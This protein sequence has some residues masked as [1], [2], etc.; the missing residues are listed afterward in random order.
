MTQFGRGRPHRSRRRNGGWR[1]RAW[2]DAV[3]SPDSASWRHSRLFS[4]N[5]RAAKCGRGV[6][7]GGAGG[8]VSGVQFDTVIV[9]AGSAGCVLA[10]R[11]S[12]DPR[13]RVCLIEAGPRDRSPLIHIPGGHS[14]HAADAPG[15]LG[16]P[17]RAAG[18]ARR[19]ARLP[20]ARARARRLELHQ[21]D[22]L[23]ARAPRRTTT[24]GPRSA[25]R[26]GPTTTCCRC[27]DAPRTSS[28]GRMPVPRQRRRTDGLGSREPGRRRPAPSSNPRCA[29]AWRANPDFNGATP[30]RGGALPGHAAPRPPLQRGRRLPA[31][32]ARAPEP[33]GADRP[34]CDAHRLRRA[35]ARRASRSRARAAR[36]A[37][38]RRA[39]LILS[40]GV[41]GS[42]QLLLLSGVGPREELERHG[43]A[44]RHELPG[45]GANL[46][47][48]VDLALVYRSDDR[49]LMGITARHG[50]PRDRRLFP[51]ARPRHGN[52]DH[53]LRRGRRVPPHARGPR[54]AGHPAP[55][56]QSGWWTTM[57]G[58]CTTAT[59]FPATSRSCA[60]RAA[61][62]VGLRSAD[63]RDAAA[64]R[65]EFPRGGGRRRD[66]GGRRQARARDH[67]RRAAR[68]ASRRGA[69]CR[70][71]RATRRS[72]RSIRRRADTIYH[73]VG[74]CRM[75]ADA[76]AVVD[77][78][79]RVRGLEGLS[80]VDASVMP[81]LVGGNTNAPTVMIAE[82]AATRTSP[83][84]RP[85]AS[86]CT[87]ENR[88]Q[89]VVARRQTR[90]AK[91][92]G[93]PE[94]RF[95]A[96][97]DSVAYAAAVS[98]HS[99]RARRRTR[100]G[101]RRGAGRAARASRRKPRA[102]SPGSS[103]ARTAS[104]SPA[105]R[106][107][108]VHVPS[109][110]T[111][112]GHDHASGQFSATGLR[113]GGPY[114]VTAQAEGMQDAIGRGPVHAARAAHLGD[115]RRAADRDSSRASR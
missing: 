53:Q 111:Q 57:R 76:M 97:T 19:P 24:T 65:P 44:V 106:V 103:S 88:G 10:N 93:D 26:A 78:T 41:F 90:D 21:R 115:A 110:T 7:F 112:H 42:P 109:G 63:P 12:A 84:T 60:R 23:H 52:P 4:L 37:S 39:K 100:D 5:R 83:E 50:A 15:E 17:D 95:P 55:L 61:G 74:T 79:L 102:S 69:V 94:R 59:A 56:R 18:R 40:A 91:Q 107:T 1:R 89:A 66:A 85:A 47:D 113:V 108:I 31:S 11:L 62:S 25:I 28:A 14:R 46:V 96:R 67:G 27:S 8:K 80:V 86:A 87:D 75:G 22:D 54:P 92:S 68:A 114:R 9:G 34:P 2:R 105:P 82:K 70:R 43:I 51:V 72:S 38:T 13:A 3:S 71:A 20:A 64:H 58:G 101:I 30:G 48:H 45:V 49:A 36:R 81:T 35:R 33:D 16:V 6:A 73:P 104:R 77:A 98:S 99:L 29:R 32:G